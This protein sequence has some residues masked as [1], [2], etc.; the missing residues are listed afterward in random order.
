LTYDLLG[1]AQSIL[2]WFI[3]LSAPSLVGAILLGVAGTLV[4]A[5]VYPDFDVGYG[6]ILYGSIGC[7]IG[8]FNGLFVDP[9]SRP[10]F[11]FSL[12]HAVIGSVVAYLIIL[13]GDLPLV[14]ATHRPSFFAFEAA[15]V[16]AVAGALAGG[17]WSFINRAPSTGAAKAT[18]F[19]WRGAVI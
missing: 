2:R 19:S 13:T 16:A 15:G 6:T 11:P 8:A 14:L 5:V 9:S 12:V 10:R 4:Y 7:L 17:L 3:R 1:R 18:F